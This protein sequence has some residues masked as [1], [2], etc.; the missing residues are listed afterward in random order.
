ME[1]QNIASNQPWHHS[2]YN[3]PTGNFNEWPNFVY[4]NSHLGNW[5]IG[6]VQRYLDDLKPSNN[7][8]QH[9]V[10]PKSQMIQCKFNPSNKVLIIEK[11]YFGM[12]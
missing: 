11:Q 10:W 7:L 12:L 4:M 1:D 5:C 9:M 6:S 8:K 2:D 3:K